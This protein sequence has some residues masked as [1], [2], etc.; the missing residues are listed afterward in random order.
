MWWIG[1][2]VIFGLFIL[3]IIY[4]QRKKIFKKRKKKEKIKKQISTE[5]KEKP[6]SV[7]KKELKVSF[8]EKSLSSVKPVI[9]K[10]ENPSNEDE[11][12][13]EVFEDFP[14]EKIRQMKNFFPKNSRVYKDEKL[15]KSAS[16]KNQI[17]DL[18]P[19]MKA[20]LFAD[21]L[22]RKED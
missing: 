19:E 1:V 16:I 5:S 2:I 8:E 22:N 15:S 18:S 12:N 21:I 6:K 10:I 20:I 13:E 4:D 7:E 14:R 9:E 3:Y 17:K 11:K